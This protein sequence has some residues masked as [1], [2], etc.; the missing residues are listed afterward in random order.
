[1][2]QPAIPL[3]EACELLFSYNR[4][5]SLALDGVN[6]RIEQ[7]SFVAIIG[8]NASG[9]STFACHCNALLFPT[10][11]AFYVLGQ[12]STAESENVLETRQRVGL[13]FQNPDNQTLMGIV[14]EDLAFGLCNLG[15][16]ASEIEQR[17]S[18]ALCIVGMEEFSTSSTQRLS[19]GQKQKVALAAVLAMR[20]SCLVLDEATAMIDPASRREIL[21]V[22]SCL[23]REQ[24]MT[25]ILITHNMSEAQLADHV[26]VLGQGRVV[27]EGSPA[28]VFSHANLLL[29][30]GLE[31]PTPDWLQHELVQAGAPPVTDAPTHTDP[32]RTQAESIL[33]LEDVSYVY[34]VGTPFATEALHK[35]TLNI[36][37]GETLVLMGKPGSGKSTLLQLLNGLLRPTQGRVLLHS[38]DI[39]QQRRLILGVRN[40]VGLVFQYPEHQLFEATVG[41]DIAFGPRMMGLE[42][43]EIEERVKRALGFVGLSP[44]LAERSPRSLSTGQKRLVAI[45]GVMAME[46]E[47]LVLDE[48]TAGLDPRTRREILASLQAYR[49]QLNGALVIATHTFEYVAALAKRIVVLDAGSVVRDG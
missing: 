35:V 33:C 13:V 37:R 3:F 9:K 47:V 15:L 32:S 21:D 14:E 27:L 40:T 17:I 2:Q 43:D 46:P 30:L 16:P 6:T 18:E 7:G 49:Q 42:P 1:M 34:D 23:C 4:G 36:R 31:L 11:G 45:A 38:Q 41:S 8:P 39:W 12:A 26:L 22:L 44:D 25:I 48:P 19:A 24:G 28:E 20:P 29:E 10:G 5:Q